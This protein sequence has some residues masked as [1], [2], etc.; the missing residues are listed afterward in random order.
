MV[1]TG[2]LLAGEPCLPYTLKQFCIENGEVVEKKLVV[3]GRKIPLTELC[4]KLLK[5]HEKFMRLD[6]INHLCQL[7]REDLCSCL[8]AIGELLVD[9]H[10]SFDDLCQLAAKHQRAR[11]LCAWHDHAT[12][13]GRGFIMITIHVKV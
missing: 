4:K 8:Q 7:S 9:N 3:D 5:A 1:N 10:I 13:L 11:A 2:H 12:I 6:S